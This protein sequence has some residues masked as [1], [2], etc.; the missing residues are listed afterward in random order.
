MSSSIF[1]T[2]LRKE[3]TFLPKIYERLANIPGWPVISNCSTPAGIVSECLD[4][5]L[6]LIIQDGWSN[7]IK[8][9]GK[10]PK[11]AILVT[12]DVVGLYPNIPH[13]LGLQS[14]R[15]RLHETG[16]YEVSA[17]QLKIILMA[18]FALKNSY[19]SLMKKFAGEHQEQ[20]WEIKL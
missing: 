15:K 14:L 12:A 8:R 1:P 16:I 3:P 4:F 17:Q 2:I 5:L 11:G 13:D 6:K 9:L 18:E 10:I 19:L 20:L 7:K